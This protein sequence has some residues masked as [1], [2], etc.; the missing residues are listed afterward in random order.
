LTIVLTCFYGLAQQS[1]DMSSNHKYDPHHPEFLE[2]EILIKFHDDI[3]V[4]ITSTRSAPFTNNTAVN[5]LLQNANAEGIDRIFYGIPKNNPKTQNIIIDGKEKALPQLHNIFRIRIDALKDTP[6]L[7]AEIQADPLVEYAEPNYL[8]YSISTFPDD[9][10]YLTG[11]QWHIDTVQAPQ[12]WDLNKGDTNQVIGIIDTGVDWDHPDLEDNLWTNW[13]EIPENGIDDDANGFVDDVHGWDFINLDYDPDDDNN[14]GT[15]V[16]GIAAAST[17]NAL[18]VAGVAWES[19]LMPVKMLQSS[20]QGNSADLAA[21]IAYASG[22]GATVINMSVGSYAESMTVKLALEY[23]YSSSFLIAA[24][25]NDGYLIDYLPMY[26]A[27]YSWV[28]GVEASGFYNEPTSFSNFDADGPLESIHADLR[29][30]EIRA[31]GYGIYSTFPDGSYHA[32]SGT[33]MSCPIVAGA[34]SMLKSH[35]PGISHEQLFVRLIQGAS[36]QRLD[37]YNSLTTT[38]VPDLKFLEY[39]IFDTLPGCDR[40]GLPDAGESIVLNIKLRNVGGNADSVWSHFS[41]GTYEDTTVARVPDSLSVFGNISAYASLSNYLDPMIIEIDSAVSHNR[42]IVFDC[43]ISSKDGDTIHEEIIFTIQNAEELIGIMDSTM[44]LT[45]DKL[46]VV[47]G[48]F[49]I[50]ST[51]HMI[52]LPGT[53]I[54]VQ[55]PVINWG[56]F[57][58]RGTAD[59]MVVVSGSSMFEMGYYNLSYLKNIPEDSKEIICSEPELYPLDYSRAQCNL[60]HCFFD[61]AVNFV[62]YKSNII[63]CDFRNVTTRP[64]RADSVIRSNFYNMGISVEFFD[65]GYNYIAHSN[66]S[67]IN[68]RTVIQGGWN[69]KSNNF[70]CQQTT[71]TY[72][73]THPNPG[74]DSCFLPPQYWGTTDTAVIDNMIFDFY[75]QIT[76]PTCIYQPILTVPS[77]SAH[78]FPWKVHINDVNPQDGTLDPF[79]PDTLKFD[80]FFNRAMDTLFTPLLTFGTREPYTQNVVNDQASWNPDSTIWTAYY[81]LG[82]ETGDGLNYIRVAEAVDD[83][84]FVIPIEDNK[85]FWFTI[86]AAGAASL[87][88]TASPDI[89]KV[90]LEWRQANATDIMGYNLY[91]YYNITDTTY[92]DTIRINTHLLI[93]TVFT[94]YALI[95]DTNYHYMYTVI[96]TDLE[97]SDFS[98]VVSATPLNTI[99]GDA[100]GDGIVDVLDI[101]TVISFILDNDPKPFLFEA[102]D[103]KNDGIID[104]LDIISIVQI[105]SEGKWSDNFNVNHY[106]HPIDLYI[107]PGIISVNN[108]SKLKAVQFE[109]TGEGLDIIDLYTDLPGI[110]LVYKN[111][112]NKI[113]GLLFSISG[114]YLPSGLIDIISYSPVNANIGFSGFGGDEEGNRIG[115]DLRD[116]H[117]STNDLMQ[118][119]AIPNPFSDQTKIGLSVPFPGDIQI[120]IYS[121]EGYKVFERNTQTSS[122]GSFNMVWKGNNNDGQKLAPGVYLCEVKVSDNENPGEHYTKV[123][124]LVLSAGGE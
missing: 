20:G 9:P 50:S 3:N 81:I 23:A 93:D 87:Y 39:T 35:F 68:V 22:N 6:S 27:C 40:D 77:D 59:S 111:V 82:L 54:K 75:D 95:P 119:E 58:A 114:E 33:S 79:G 92:S 53:H 29:N 30:Y 31:P 103:Q 120:T 14:H 43:M 88:F 52:A 74:T 65:D 21:A 121:L 113:V 118:L 122:D 55:K 62:L 60:D 78:G 2:N 41:L 19:K 45:P 69:F 10:I 86:Q 84:G 73:C 1:Y 115:F 7:A 24:S 106:S 66:F 11:A 72:Y 97:E 98:K 117:L 90:D 105:I 12:A 44:Y 18:G 94:D 15:H 47:N 123:L 112:D 71:N 8:I 110:E 64:R 36:N 89:G 107:D 57:E 5:A 99:P 49:R 91:R 76:L 48:S 25:G 16:A 124:K 42:D 38:P 96:G 17:N 26:P 67:K 46:W 83:E 61:G 85:R 100:N 34:V 32:L 13:D 80:V 104:V 108:D 101:T 37:L 63:D 51:G 28:F 116:M 102:A 4:H 109:F 70:I 56:L